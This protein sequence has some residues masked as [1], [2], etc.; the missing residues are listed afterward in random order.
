ME[1]EELERISKNSEEASRETVGEMDGVEL[2][3]SVNNWEDVNASNTNV[4]SET[5]K[6]DNLSI[7]I[8]EWKQ[9]DFEKNSEAEKLKIEESRIGNQEDISENL[10]QD[11]EESSEIDCEKL[12]I[13]KRNSKG[14]VSLDNGV[15]RQKLMSLPQ[16]EDIFEKKNI[17]DGGV[18]WKRKLQMEFEELERNLHVLEEDSNEYLVS[19][20]CTENLKVAEDPFEE[21]KEDF[22]SFFEYLD[23]MEEME[24]DDFEHFGNQKDNLVTVDDCKLF[25]EGGSL[26][27]KSSS[28]SKQVSF[29][30]HQ[31]IGKILDEIIESID[32]SDEPVDEVKCGMFNIYLK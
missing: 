1:F 4:G 7:I 2:K 17:F 29:G 6:E 8:D 12:E 25:E 23:I 18:A 28:S 16:S 15:K 24:M 30:I 13:K 19:D 21:A 3:V 9:D 20:T 22:Q 31:A 32:A 10:K 5:A 27:Q 14:D 26:R 11:L